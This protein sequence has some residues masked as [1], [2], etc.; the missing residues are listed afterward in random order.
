M[1]NNNI[2]TKLTI[3][4]LIIILI[5]MLLIVLVVL[6][7]LKSTRKEIILDRLISGLS[8]LNYTYTLNDGTK[9]KVFGMHEK[10][11]TSESITYIDYENKKSVTI[12][13]E[14]LFKEEFINNGMKDMKYY[15]SY[16]DSYFNKNYIYKYC[17]KENIEGKECLK[18]EFIFKETKAEETYMWIDDLT[19]VIKKIECYQYINNKKVKVKDNNNYDFC[20][21]SN[22]KEDVL[23]TEEELS[24]YSADTS[25][26]MTDVD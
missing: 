23:A 5:M 18:I 1:F 10:I 22:T 8:N 6:M 13:P 19:N 9:V 3:M 26:Y 17:G 21:G 4:I 12:Y 16:I 7:I 15:N 14:S 24:Q 20:I 25:G 11:E 2:K